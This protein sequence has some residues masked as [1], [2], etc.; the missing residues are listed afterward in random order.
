LPKY[1]FLPSEKFA[2]DSDEDLKDFERRQHIWWDYNAVIQCAYRRGKRKGIASS[3]KEKG[4][5]VEV[6]AKYTGL[7]AEEIEEL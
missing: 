7:S 5:A 2:L 6:I 3:M 4:V 1:H